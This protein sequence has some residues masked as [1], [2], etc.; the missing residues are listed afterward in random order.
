MNQTKP[1]S[2]LKVLDELVT[3]VYRD[4]EQWLGFMAARYGV[5]DELIGYGFESDWFVAGARAHRNGVELVTGP[6]GALP[7]PK[8]D[9]ELLRRAEV[10]LL[11]LRMIVKDRE[12][13]EP[14]A[15]A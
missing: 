6:N 8:V 4:T 9:R 14:G 10:A 2:G 15:D 11:E 13:K 1:P 5:F 7:V 3:G 12:R